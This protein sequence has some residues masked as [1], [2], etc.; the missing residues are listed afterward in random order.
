MRR[1][2]GYTK[3]DSLGFMH[4]LSD[5]EMIAAGKVAAHSAELIVARL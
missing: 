2:H 5:A 3:L 1:S 4:V